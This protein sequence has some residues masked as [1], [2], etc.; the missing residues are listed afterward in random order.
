VFA[1]FAYPLGIIGIYLEDYLSKKKALKWTYLDQE[2]RI[3][4]KDDV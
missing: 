1:V 4:V 2:K 3:F